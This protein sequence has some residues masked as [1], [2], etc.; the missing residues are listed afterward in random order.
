M[1]ELLALTSLRVNPRSEGKRLYTLSMNIPISE[2]NEI[3]S[4]IASAMG[5]YLIICEVIRTV[6]I[7]SYYNQTMLENHPSN[8]L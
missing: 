4:K 3:C 1:A 8:I 5:Y 6:L 2:V 7:P